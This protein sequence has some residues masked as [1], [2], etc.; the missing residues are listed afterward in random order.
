MSNNRKEI[1]SSIFFV[2]CAIAYFCGTFSIR[3]Y[4]A[5]GV[6]VLSSASVPRALAVGLA[7]LGLINA[8]TYINKE[9]E[10]KAIA[11][12]KSQEEQVAKASV[13]NVATNA[14]TKKAGGVDVDKALADAEKM[15]DPEVLSRK[16]I[17]LTV[18][19]LVVYALLLDPLGFIISTIVYIFAQGVL[20]TKIAERK[21]K[22]IPIAILSV[23]S[24][25]V[26]YFLFNNL[27]LLMLPEG[28]FGF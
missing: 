13:E 28:L 6:T 10:D 9:K 27:L 3:D 22:I 16:D 23:V 19:N 11:T 4:N 21:K 14:D 1:L 18:V 24:S 25:V 12:E 2:V 15:E 20:M 8:V 5:F 7:V 17:I 26:I